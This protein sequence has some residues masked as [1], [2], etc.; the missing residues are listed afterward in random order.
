MFSS[1]IGFAL[2]FGLLTLLPLRAQTALDRTSPA[3]AS[4]LAATLCLSTD[5]MAFFDAWE[6]YDEAFVYAEADTVESG[7]VLVAFVIFSDC[8]PD[9]QGLC[10]LA[11]DF[12]FLEPDGAEHSRLDDTDLWRSM[13]APPAA[14]R[15]LGNES[16]V[17]SLEPA[18][19][20]GRWRVRAT[21][22]DRVGGKVLELEKGFEVQPA[23][24]PVGG[25]GPLE[26][27]EYLD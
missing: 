6:E 12:V 25:G 26:D 20:P 24:V 27:L 3:D 23:S 4:G 7:G 10:D 17:L 14:Q 11:A 19:P 16:G 21:L 9:E 22:R 18:D 1:P 13:T 8:T 2:A 15:E 5:P